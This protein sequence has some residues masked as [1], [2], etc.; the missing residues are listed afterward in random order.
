MT[1]I[2]VLI[3]LAIVPVRCVYAGP[4]DET[5][6]CGPPD[7]AIDGSIKRSG[8]VVAAFKRIHPCPVTGKTTGACSGWQINHVIPLACGGCDAVANMDWMPVQIKTCSSWYCRDR[9]EAKIYGAGI[10][11]TPFCKPPPLV[12]P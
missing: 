7:R 1:K 4:L 12:T 3:L 2:I 10:P 5:R 8:A 9:F 11:D 6:Y